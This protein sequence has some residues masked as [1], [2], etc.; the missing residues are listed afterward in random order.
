MRLDKFLTAAGVSTRSAASKSARAGDITVNGVRVK[1]A[2]MQI[3]PSN[4]T[5]M[6]HG[7]TIT[8][9][10]H[11]YVMLNKPEGY[12]S[13]TE[14]SRAPVVNALLDEHDAARVFP[15]G[16]LDKYTVGLMLLTDDG[17]LSHRLLAPARHVAKTYRYH[18]RDPLTEDAAGRMRE[19]VHIEGGYLTAP[20][21]IEI[22]TPTTGNITLTEGKYHQIKQ[23]FGA[24]GNEITALERLTFGPLTLDGKLER[25]EWR[26]LSD[27]EINALYAAADLKKIKNTTDI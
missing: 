20:C 4:D 8:W 18:C 13:A 11:I 14:D 17:E 24:V 12:V 26:Y 25:G 23:M 19:G 5:V 10:E 16:R 3:D 1:D 6:L 27:E 2:G 7:Q 21:G 9:R 15:C 22:I